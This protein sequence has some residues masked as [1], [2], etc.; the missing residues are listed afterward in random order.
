MASVPVHPV[1]RFI[2]NLAVAAPADESS[3]GQLL[4]RF[5]GHRDD[6]A[7]AEL[8]RRHGPMVL[9]VCR[10]TLGDSPDADDAF[11]AAFLVL[12]RRAGSVGRPELLGN[13]LYGVAYRTA[14]KAR[15]A[16]ARRRARLKP[17][18]EVAVADAVEELVWR[19]LRP[20]LDE[21]LNRLP[22]R[23][24]VPVVLCDLEGQTHEE[25]ARRLGCPRE[26]L[27]TRL[28]RARARLRG[29]LTR[30]GLTLSG[31]LFATL[32]AEGA[33]VPD[34][35]A[36]L[37]TQA[38]AAGV[39][40]PQVAALTGGVLRA[41]FWSQLTRAT[42]LLLGV[43]LLGA[44]TTFLTYRAFPAGQPGGAAQA[45]A[46]PDQPAAGDR[47]KLQGTWK[48]VSTE[49]MGR[50]N[51]ERVG[52]TWVFT[53]NRI[54]LDR[55][56]PKTEYSYQIDSAADPK[57]ID[58]APTE[59]S[60]VG[61]HYRGIYRLDRDRLT[62]C[63]A[64][65]KKG[66]TSEKLRPTALATQE[67]ELRVLWVL[68]RLARPGK[69]ERARTD[70]EIIQGAWVGVSG[71]REGAPLPEDEARDALIT[72][73]GDE[74]F[75]EPSREKL[76][77][78][79]ELDSNKSPKVLRMTAREGP[80]KGRTVSWIYEL[81]G[82]RLKLCGDD[83]GSKKPPTAFATKPGS[84]LY[85]LVLRRETA[86]DRAR[87]RQPPLVAPAARPPDQA[88]RDREKLQGTWQAVSGEESDKPLSDDFVKNYKATFT[89]DKV[90][91]SAIDDSGE[92]TITLDP[93]KDPKTIDVEIS[94]SEK[95]L[96][97]Y[98]VEGDTLKLC[99]VEDKDGNERPT[100][101]A[102]TG[103]QVLIVF[104][105]QPEKKKP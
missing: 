12:V 21:E 102:G 13:W 73:K 72:F 100:E 34:G 68:E 87:P 77:I 95:A 5:A 1:L 44:G 55:A 2:R 67:G 30:R 97:I 4:A 98:Q 99:M 84:G 26:T 33:A 19:D 82:D 78:T 104:K 35:L 83:K 51:K 61:Y 88:R 59:K 85:L 79:Y 50:A 10:R 23:Y 62:I 42:A 92:G 8:V 52:E 80:D 40:S 103:K 66:E 27:T 94:D 47:E 64:V 11:Q 63:A 17:L 38:A 101:F 31:A 65:V 71:E 9:G 91:L 14:L 22:D 18:P 89:G 43:C 46:K 3:D 54:T 20:V 36:D 60:E 69:P 75:L 16:A 37:T 39:V 45:P 28:T 48:L 76:R 58:L 24:R 15:A 105:R 86:E 90:K 6:A 93:T 32:L 81:T 49:W 53:D 57:H 56:A 29:R 96:G 25:A 74:L 41:M 7:F 70:Q